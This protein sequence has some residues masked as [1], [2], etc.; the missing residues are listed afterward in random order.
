MRIQ[1]R[2]ISQNLKNGQIQ[3]CRSGEF[4]HFPRKHFSENSIMFMKFDFSDLISIREISS[5]VEHKKF[6]KIKS[7]LTTYWVSNHLRV[8]KHLQVLII[9][10]K[11][12]NDLFQ[13]FKIRWTKEHQKWKLGTCNVDRKGRRWSCGAGRGGCYGRRVKAKSPWWGCS[14]CHL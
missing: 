4:Y 2:V 6:C 7:F 10:S 12:I 8:W 14:G 1:M 5:N 3:I 9:A 13:S 11:L